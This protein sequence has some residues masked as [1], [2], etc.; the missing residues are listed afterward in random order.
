M[1]KL[2]WSDYDVTKMP[3]KDLER[4]ARHQ[5]ILMDCMARHSED[6]RKIKEEAQKSLKDQQKEGLADAEGKPI[7]SAIKQKY[8]IS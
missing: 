7:L 4:I 8:R 5:L 2:K 1:E 6:I 3:R